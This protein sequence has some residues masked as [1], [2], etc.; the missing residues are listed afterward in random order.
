MKKHDY[1]SYKDMNEDDGMSDDDQEPKDMQLDN[2]D[3]SD[4]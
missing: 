3:V 1:K 4:N 2:E